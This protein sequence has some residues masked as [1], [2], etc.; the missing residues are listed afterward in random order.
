ML[1]PACDVRDRQELRG[2]PT[3]DRQRTHAPLQRRNALLE[4]GVRG[5]HDPAVDV[6]ELPQAEQ[7]RGVLRRLEHVTVRGV[8]GGLLRAR[9]GVGLLPGVNLQRLE[10]VRHDCAS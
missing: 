2:V 3:G 10:F 4:H 6:P 7:V 8:D 5:V 1:S 9:G